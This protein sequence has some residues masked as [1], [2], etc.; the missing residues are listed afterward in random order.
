MCSFDSNQ[1]FLYCGAHSSMFALFPEHCN[2]PPQLLQGGIVRM[3]V[4]HA[5][6]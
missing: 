5:L 3:R 1:Q 6:G 4:A 2:Q